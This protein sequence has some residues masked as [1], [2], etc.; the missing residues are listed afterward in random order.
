M[1]PYNNNSSSPLWDK[2]KL[3]IKS[4]VIF[5]I[6]LFLWIPTFFI[7]AMVKERE[8][9]QKEAIAD[10]SGKWAGKQTVTGPLLMIPYDMPVTQSNGVTTREKQY[11]YF[12]A[13][14]LYTSR[15]V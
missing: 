8:G 13:C 14:L 2:G 9:R 15:C 11:A 6:G 4:L 7:M 10:I 12:M 3:F 5:G 1:D